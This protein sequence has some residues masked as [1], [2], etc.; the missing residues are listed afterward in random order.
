[1]CGSKPEKERFIGSALVLKEDGC[2][3]LFND[4]NGEILGDEYIKYERV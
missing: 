2:R 1:V 4:S 3:V